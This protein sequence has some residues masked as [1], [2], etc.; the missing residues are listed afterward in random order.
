MSN[1]RSLCVS[2]ASVV[3][4]ADTSLGCGKGGLDWGSVGY[5][6]L[7]MCWKRCRNFKDNSAM[8]KVSHRSFFNKHPLLSLSPP[9][10]APPHTRT[11]T[12]QQ[13]Q[14]LSTSS[15]FWSTPLPPANRVSRWNIVPTVRPPRH[16]AAFSTLI[17]VVA[18]GIHESRHTCMHAQR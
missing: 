8:T 17:R 3:S 10:P 12:F 15:V 16:R 9:P 11:H 4:H 14:T 18:S 5:V 6:N 7:G 2:N 1:K 13:K